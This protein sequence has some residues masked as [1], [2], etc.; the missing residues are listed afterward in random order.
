MDAGL[1]IVGLKSMWMPLGMM[2]IANVFNLLRKMAG[3]PL[4]GKL[5][6]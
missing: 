1:P 2:C 3:I 4:G 5:E 6:Q